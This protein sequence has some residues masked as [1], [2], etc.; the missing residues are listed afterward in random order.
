[1]H[2]HRYELQTF[3]RLFVY[4]CTRRD[5]ALPRSTWC[6]FCSPLN[7]QSLWQ[8]G[9]GRADLQQV[10]I[11]W[12]STQDFRQEMSRVD[13]K[14]KVGTSCQHEQ[15]G[16]SERRSGKAGLASRRIHSSD[17][18]AASHQALAPLRQRVAISAVATRPFGMCGRQRDALSSC[19][20]RLCPVRSA[21]SDSSSAG[22]RMRQS[23][24]TG[25][26]QSYRI[27]ASADRLLLFGCWECEGLP[28][29]RCSTSAA[30]VGRVTP[31]FR[32]ANG[33]SFVGPVPLAG[34][35]R[36][37]GQ[38]NG[39]RAPASFFR[40]EVCLIARQARCSSCAVH[41]CCD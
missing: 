25:G 29:Y 22:R 9:L 8:L 12:R 3:G 4:M 26:L 32:Q 33:P 30:G 5:A 36:Q 19:S 31:Y 37:V 11:A 41:C 10:S 24:R 18:L 34:L 1:M 40:C 28:D 16:A 23:V 14:R 13:A 27:R 15:P 39:Q 20:L 6:T 21:L 35:P 7:V 2:V 38:S 17:R